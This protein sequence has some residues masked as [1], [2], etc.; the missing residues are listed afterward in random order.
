MEEKSS[1][2]GLPVACR[3]PNIFLF[4]AVF[5][6]KIGTLE[7]RED[8]REKVGERKGLAGEGAGR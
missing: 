6:K 4:F 5:P 2:K 3:Q 1:M 7:K 8:W